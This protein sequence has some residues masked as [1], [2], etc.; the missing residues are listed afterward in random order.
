MAVIEGVKDVVLL[1]AVGFLLLSV[2]CFLYVW[3]AMR[4]EERRAYSYEPLEPEDED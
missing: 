1:V 3:W 2:A 4:K